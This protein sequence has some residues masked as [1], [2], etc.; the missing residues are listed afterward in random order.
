M[1]EKGEVN[2]GATRMWTPP[3]SECDEPVIQ[4]NILKVSA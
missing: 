2:F 4:T 1:A 3:Y